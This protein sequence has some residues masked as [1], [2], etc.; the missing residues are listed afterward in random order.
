MSR[1]F[2]MTEL[3]R[4]DCAWTM[5]ATRPLG[6]ILR[7]MSSSRKNVGVAKAFSLRNRTAS[8]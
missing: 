7:R 6:S 8:A 5:R 2:W 1:A 3:R 4:L